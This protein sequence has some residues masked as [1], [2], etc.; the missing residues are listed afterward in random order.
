L[1][2]D[3]VWQVPS[4]KDEKIIAISPLIIDLLE[5]ADGFPKKIWEYCTFTKE[6]YFKRKKKKRSI[7][8]I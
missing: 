4:K 8:L 1:A 3:D 6:Q 5:I 7:D 2:L